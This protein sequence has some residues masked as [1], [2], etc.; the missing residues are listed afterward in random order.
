MTEKIISFKQ[1]RKQR[2]RLE[3]EKTSTANREK[4]GRSKGEKQRVK[5][6]ADNAITHLD[7]HKLSDD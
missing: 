5:L 1:A 6:D 3:K 4:F 7:D 2:Q